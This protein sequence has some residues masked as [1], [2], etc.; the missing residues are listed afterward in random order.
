MVLRH[1]LTL[2]HAL[3]YSS[4]RGFHD[5]YTYIPV[6]GKSC[7][8]PYIRQAMTIMTTEDVHDSNLQ[9]LN[10]EN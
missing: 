4:L 9:Q 3:A 5:S 6:T 7:Y 2:A 8:T 10:V 1:V